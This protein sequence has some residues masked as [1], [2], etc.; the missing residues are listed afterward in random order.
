MNFPPLTVIEASAGTG[1]TFALVTRLLKLIFNVTEP[2]RI[3]AL[4]FSRM[5]AGEIFNSFIERLSKAAASDEV[6]REESLRMGREL[7]RQDFTDMLR[8]VIS[9][10]H[11]SLIGT[12]DSFLMRIVRMIPL[13]LGLEGE[14]SV[15]S[16][17]RG[18]VERMRLVGEM[19]MRESDEAKAIFR[20]AFRYALDG[21][22]AKNFQEKFSNFIVSWHLKYRDIAEKIFA[23]GLSSDEELKA[24]VS[25]W[26][27]EST[28]LGDDIPEGLNVTLPEIRK[29]ADKLSEY[30]GKSGA[31]TFIKAVKDFS[32][33]IP[34]I[35]KCMKSEE[36][37][38]IA[39]AKMQL[40]KIAK[41]LK[42]TRGIFLLMH[43]YE[44]AYAS[45]VRA[46]GLITF[47]DM[48]RLLNSLPE[49]VKLPLEYRMDAQFDHWALD[50]FQDTSH[51][52]WKA[53]K[54]LIYEKSH[55][56]SGNSVFIVGDRKQSIYEWRGGDVEILGHQVEEAQQEG[57]LLESLDESYRYVQVISDAVNK[58]FDENTVHGAITMDEAPESAKW[59]CRE[60][61]SFN[62]KFEGYV[63]VIQAE[64]KDRQASASDFFVPIENALNAVKPWERNIETAILVR[65]GT[66]GEKI[67]AH[68]KSKGITKVVFEGD[69]EVSDT[70]VLSVMMDLVKLA[71][72]PND[73]F[74]YA[75]IK[76]SPVGKAMYPNGVPDAA[77][78]S[79]SLLRDFTKIGM[80]RKF[81]DVREL[82][83]TV[84]DSWNDFVESRF[85]DFIKCAAEFEEIRDATMRLSDFIEFISR[86]KRR[87]FAEPGVVRIMT[88]HQSK[89]LGFDWVI[90]PF[91][92]WENM[93]GQRHVGVLEHSDPDWVMVNPGCSVDMANPVL[94]EAE[95]KRQQVQIYNSLCLDYVAM[96]R[97][98]LAMTI[99]LHPQNKTQ[100]ASPERFSD[101][102]RLVGLT[103]QGD[104]L[105]YT[106]VEHK[107]YD[108]ERKEPLAIKRSAR[109]KIRKS[110]PSE[111]F[112]D[113]L[114]AD[115]LFSDNLDKAAK[116]G[117]ELHSQY[118]LIEWAQGD[119]LNSLPEGFRDA[120][121]KKHS[122]D[123]V[124]REKSYEL[125]IDG[126]WET[127][128]FDRV[129][130]SQENGERSAT[131]Y[132]FKT[133]TLKPNETVAEFET[134]LLKMYSR[135]MQ[136]YRKAL[137]MLTGIPTEKIKTVLLSSEAQKAIH[138]D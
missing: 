39:V 26:G 60:H 116:R 126:K 106:K 87:D 80:V 55:S 19:M 58:I 125:F 72:H 49:G 45:K 84:P 82:L 79:A 77:E 133:T 33:T 53:L 129:V 11:L 36:V 67:L 23:R 13:E 34:K 37:A 31:D 123:S 74:A 111:S 57:N 108:A 121:T 90:L 112:Y 18:P 73:K 61:K 16:E 105:W 118:E 63:E 7:S 96:T 51:G 128:Q 91:Y 15:I 119:K 134:R 114:S 25:A 20:Q 98:K 122:T 107:Q 104:P 78:L 4:T 93:M 132:D 66:V 22:G 3:V 65:T 29:L 35:P 32:G 41:S 135:Q 47:D 69:S 52:Q 76:Y 38:T 92:E 99:I 10:Q 17:Y 127:G 131:I 115:I 30:A 83:K 48:P 130:F 94:E 27:D 103:T 100:P 101:L 71:E 85:E 59:K 56:D 9:R 6:A 89:G 95:R 97:A 102:V 1:K 5:A 70:P 137:C 62:K 54:N 42:Q 12:L 81:R 68:L 110:R 120:F 75:H 124:W 88:M 8:K 2:E 86:K 117:V 28:I 113:G 46:R 21:T 44:S 24:I 64:K 136:S 43:A 50:E 138:I 109:Q 14:L 40:W